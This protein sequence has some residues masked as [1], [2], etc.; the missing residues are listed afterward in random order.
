MRESPKEDKDLSPDQKTNSASSM[1]ASVKTSLDEFSKRIL[2][3]SNALSTCLGKKSATDPTAP[4]TEG[5]NKSCKADRTDM[6]AIH[7]DLS[8]FAK[9][10]LS[11]AN[12]S[13]FTE[14]GQKGKKVDEHF[15]NEILNL[16]STIVQQQG[17]E[18]LANKEAAE[19]ETFEQIQRKMIEVNKMKTDEMES[20]K[21]PKVPLKDIKTLAKEAMTTPEDRKKKEEEAEK[22]KKWRNS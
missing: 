5:T 11:V 18:K 20:K 21:G 16:Y 14:D 3:A 19:D 7:S 6:K 8:D 17:L 22:A 1:D 10:W 4:V 9:Q 15:V 12:A 2:A 13:S